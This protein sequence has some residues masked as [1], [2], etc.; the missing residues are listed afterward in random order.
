LV[1]KTQINSWFLLHKNA[2]AHR[3]FL[4]KDFLANNNATAPHHPPYSLDLSLPNFHLSPRLKS[5]MRGRRFCYSTSVIKNAT[6][7]LKRLQQNG[8][9]EY[10]QHI[11]SLWQECVGAQVDC[12]EENVA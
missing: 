6:E 2:P 1:I 7:E 8:F 10:F 11:Y 4:F 12:F 9:Q 5:G 3:V